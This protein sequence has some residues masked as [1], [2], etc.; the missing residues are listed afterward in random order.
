MGAR[1]LVSHHLL[2]VLTAQVSEAQLKTAVSTSSLQRLCLQACHPH[3]CGSSECHHRGRCCFFFRAY[4]RECP[5]CFPSCTPPGMLCTMALMRAYSAIS[6]CPTV[7]PP[8]CLPVCLWN[9]RKISGIDVDTADNAFKLVTD[10]TLAE[11]T[12]AYF[13]GCKPQHVPS[14]ASKV[15]K[16][17]RLWQ[18]WEEQTGVAAW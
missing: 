3:G 5:L 11:V 7:C 16:Q 18:L 4:I 12:S 14:A 1:H 9:G 13:V 6:F 17:A 2:S 15:D 8:G 10:P